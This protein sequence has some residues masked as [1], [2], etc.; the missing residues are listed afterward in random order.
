MQPYRKVQGCVY[1]C[2]YVFN[3][4]T[5]CFM[6]WPKAKSITNAGTEGI[7]QWAKKAIVIGLLW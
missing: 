3:H 2:T 4:P 5:F 1:Q 6:L 7:G